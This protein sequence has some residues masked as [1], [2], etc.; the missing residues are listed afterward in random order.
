MAEG[1]ERKK[2]SSYFCNCFFNQCWEKSGGE[3]LEKFKQPWQPE[4]S[5][6][7]LYKL[8]ENPCIINI[9]RDYVINCHLFITSVRLKKENPDIEF[10]FH[11]LL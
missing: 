10:Q 1:E 3:S 11:K 9:D 7:N 6:I 5:G 4:C 8:A 2:E